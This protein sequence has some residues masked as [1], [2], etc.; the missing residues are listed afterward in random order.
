MLFVPGVPQCFVCLVCLVCLVCVVCLVSLVCLVFL[1]CV[2]IVPGVSGVLR[3]AGVLGVPVV[4]VQFESHPSMYD[5][6]VIAC[7]YAYHIARRRF[8]SRLLRTCFASFFRRHGP[9]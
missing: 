2:R 4:S 6:V 3:V 5:I 7:T 1:K 9:L 8:G